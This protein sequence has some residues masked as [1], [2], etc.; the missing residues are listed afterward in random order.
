[1]STF[2]RLCD[3]IDKLKIKNKIF[4]QNP[5][6]LITITAPGNFYGG[7]FINGCM[8]GQTIIP[9]PFIIFSI[10]GIL[11]IFL[12]TL[13]WKGLALWKAG[14]KGNAIW[15]VVLLLVNT[16]GILEIIYYYC[17]DKDNK[18]ETN[19]SECRATC[20]HCVSQMSEKI[21]E[22]ASKVEKTAEKWWHKIAKKIKSK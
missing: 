3:I 12:W 5:Y 16:F 17:V 7:H 19:C 4:M 6:E 18:G 2:V 14:K 13:T 21:S 1:M 20:T 8:Q 15:F 9:L 10:I 11:A 22:K